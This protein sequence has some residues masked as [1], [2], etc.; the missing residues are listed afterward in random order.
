M[1]P[2]IFVVAN[3]EIRPKTKFPPFTKGGDV[4]LY[5]K[6]TFSNENVPKAYT[7]TQIIFDVY[8]IKQYVYLN[9]KEAS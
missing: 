6:D 4:M 8:T 9:E 3:K 2:T 1:W 5:L 7:V